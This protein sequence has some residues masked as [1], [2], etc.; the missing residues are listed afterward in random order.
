MMTAKEAREKVEKA[1]DKV[2]NEEFDV[3]MSKIEDAVSEM[4]CR[5]TTTVA[6]H[7]RTECKLEN[8]GYKVKSSVDPRNNTTTI[9][10]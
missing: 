6:I 5:I 3:I 7:R 1:L 8:L 10:W 2:A 9:S 4:K